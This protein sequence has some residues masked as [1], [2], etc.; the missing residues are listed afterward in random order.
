MLSPLFRSLG[1][2]KSTSPQFR[3]ISDEPIDDGAQDSLGLK[4]QAQTFADAVLESEAHSGL[5]FGVDGPWGVGKT[6]FVNLAEQRWEEEKHRVIVCRLEPLRYASEPDLSGRLISEISVAIQREVFVPELRPVASRYSRLIK[7]KAD[8]S[9]LG[10]R[11]SLEPSQESLDEL[12]QDIDDVLKRID[13]RV[14]IV[15]DDLDRLDA[16][17]TNSVLFATQRTFKLSQATYVLC[18]DT[19]VLAS[20]GEDGAR[21]RVFLEKFVA[22]KMSLFV[23]SCSIQNYLRKG[24]QLSAPQLGA[25]SSHRRLYLSALLEEFAATLNDDLGAR[26]QP[27]AGDLRKAKRF[28]N[29][30]QMIQQNGTSDLDRTDF[31]KRDLI[32][33]TLLHLHYPGL[34]RRIYAEETEGRSGIFSLRTE[35]KKF[36]NAADFLP[37]LEK[38]ESGAAFLLA[39]LFDANILDLGSRDSV[40]SED[41][42]SRA[43]FNK[44]PFRNL[45]R[46]LT[47]IVRFVTPEPQDTFVLYKTAV[48]EVL[49]GAKVADVLNRPDF[50]SERWEHAHEQFWLL[51]VEKSYGFKRAITAQ[52]AIDTLVDV[53]PKYSALR[54]DDRGLRQQSI[55]SLLLLLDRV[56]WGRQVE[57]SERSAPNTPENLLEI[58]W[59]IFGEKAYQG[60]GLIERMASDD[61]GVLGW[62]DLMLFR[63][64]CSHDRGGQ[65]F[66]LYSA[67]SAHQDI[68]APTT[69]VVSELTKMQMRY[70]SQRIFARF[71]QTY[72]DSRRNFFAEAR[73]ASVDALLGSASAQNKSGANDDLDAQNAGSLDQRAD[74][75]RA[76]V[77]SF[78]IYQLSNLKPPTGSG[79]GCGHYDE[80][81]AND[82]GGIARLM[83]EYV[84]G[85]CFNPEDDPRNVVHFLDHCL[86]HLSRSFQGNW[87][88]TKT[89][90]AGGLDPLELGRY[91][92][93][94]EQIIRQQSEELGDRRIVTHNYIALYRDDLPGVFAVLDELAK[95]PE[96]L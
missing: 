3:F 51:L 89:D 43:C 7:G 8:F 78:V 85:T 56:G 83:N 77:T 69:G 79:V 44:K 12:I 93:Q 14:I 80:E 72:I 58:A 32:N 60:K 49:G 35:E 36:M 40:T 15:I 50:L 26:Y 18:Y 27:F 86:L 23:D 96:G 68:E 10:F 66:N 34:F 5:V 38:Q 39:Q 74:A 62:N 76:G 67:L 16:K 19:E 17:A 88:A 63:L 92:G 13:R 48:D 25:M 55:Y 73:Q 70:L 33:L 9:F 75:A 46:Y 59:R 1:K 31:N 57:A 29:A 87:I 37:L 22:V 94:H 47:H 20:R 2:P 54:A 28:V 90:L 6:S 11:L 53:L 64:Y 61:R 82:S 91:W 81:G 45:E 84:F 52:D 24:W 95:A 4:D 71:K 42:T 30:V 21:S 65:L 41:R